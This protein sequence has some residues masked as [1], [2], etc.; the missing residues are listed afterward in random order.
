M[1]NREIIMEH[2]TSSPYK[3]ELVLSDYQKVEVQSSQCVDHL[4]LYIKIENS[5]ISDAYFNGEACAI[6]TSSCSILIENVLNKTLE[7]AKINIEEFEKMIHD[8]PYDEEI[9]KNATVFKDI[10]HQGNRK[11]CAYL[12]YQGLKQILE[13]ER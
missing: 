7:E 11:S 2:Y 5:K 12:P 1:N 6:A 13:D 4:F 8:E 10:I 9:L 3:K